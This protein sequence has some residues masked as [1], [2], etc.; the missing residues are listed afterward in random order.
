MVLR[1]VDQ[2]SVLVRV[3]SSVSV[4]LGELR[5]VHQLGSLSWLCVKVVHYTDTLELLWVSEDSAVREKG[6][7]TIFKKILW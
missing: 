1:R 7:P 2:E 6:G 3:V 5:W 4:N